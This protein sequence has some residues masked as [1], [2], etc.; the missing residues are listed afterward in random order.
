MIAFIAVAAAAV[1]IF[2]AVLSAEI[3]VDAR[4]QPIKPATLSR[5]VRS[6]R[7]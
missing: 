4:F 6:S 1:V 3:S 2:A 5:R 7:W